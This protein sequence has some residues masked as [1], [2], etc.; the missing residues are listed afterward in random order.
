MRTSEMDAS[1]WLT[2]VC[3]CFEHDIWPHLKSVFV[4]T[5]YPS[6]PYVLRPFAEDEIPTNDPERRARI[7]KFNQ[8]LSR[9]RITIEHAIGMLKGRFPSLKE[10]GPHEAMDDIYD[11]IEAMMVIHNICI[12][13]GD[14]PT[15]F[16]SIPTEAPADGMEGLTAEDLDVGGEVIGDDDDDMDI[17]LWETDD[18]LRRAG[19]AMR[20]HL[21]NQLFPH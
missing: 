13:L 8:H 15:D 21:L 10:M 2:K 3:T 1:F 14:H 17:P 18:G 20:E 12:N 7:L 4:Y 11:A 19:L 5:G 6:S 16:F 9:F